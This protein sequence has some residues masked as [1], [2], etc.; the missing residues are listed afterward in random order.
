MPE[1]WRGSR[2]KDPQGAVDHG[3]GQERGSTMS[4]IE[5]GGQVFVVDVVTR[6]TLTHPKWSLVGIGETLDEAMA[7]FDAEA[8]E[9]YAVFHD[10]N[11]ADLSYEANRFREWL[12]ANYGGNDE[13]D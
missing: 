9:L 7:D 10:D 2:R 11:P 4:T 12:I 8:R 1:V 13:H 3:H 6:V 5:V